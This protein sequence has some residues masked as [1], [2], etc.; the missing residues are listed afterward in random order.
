MV[1]NNVIPFRTPADSRRGGVPQ[2]SPEIQQ[3]TTDEQLLDGLAGL[4][5]AAGCPG[6]AGA[7][8]IEAGGRCG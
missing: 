8:V 7:F 4:F 5:R 6:L 3:A 2:A 1:S